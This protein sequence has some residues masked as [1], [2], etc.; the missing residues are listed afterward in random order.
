MSKRTF[1]KYF[2]NFMGL[3]NSKPQRR[4][5]FLGLDNAGK[6]TILKAMCNESPTSIAPTRGFNV[7]Q[8]K[9]N[10][11]ELNI[12]DIGGQR[13]LRAYWEN[14][15]DKVNGIVWVIDSADERRM[16][17]TGEELAALLQEEK[18]AGVPIIV[19][20]NKQDLATAKTAD[21]I[22]LELNLHMIR[23][24]NWQIQACSAIDGTGLKEALSWLDHNLK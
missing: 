16:E 6:T 17:E 9:T 1:D 14:Y 24:R 2:K 18:L 5:L 20:A 11:L 23:N 15:Y 13:T 3:N 22:S 19:L 4:I 8:L 21:E 12:W 7:K 10:K